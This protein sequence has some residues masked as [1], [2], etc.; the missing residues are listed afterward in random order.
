MPNMLTHDDK[1]KSFC[2][3]AVVRMDSIGAMGALYA[4][5]NRCASEDIWKI[6]DIPT[7]VIAGS[8]DRLIPIEKIRSFASLPKHS[9]FEE[10]ND[11][12]HMPMLEAPDKVAVVL[13][14]YIN[15]I[16]RNS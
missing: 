1:V 6:L 5:A 10:I 11:V 4:M 12:G 2:R 13:M 8:D 15:N 9:T 3:N 16:R 14:K 7:M